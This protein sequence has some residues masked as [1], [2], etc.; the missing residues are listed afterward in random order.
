MCIKLYLILHLIN[1][2]VKKYC[3][4][5]KN[6]VEY[7]STKT[8]YYMRAGDR[9]RLF[10]RYSDIEKDAVKIVGESNKSKEQDVIDNLKQ[11]YK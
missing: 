11:N 9:G 4:Y 3:N 7:K 5:F 6:C 8:I 2:K 10:F 1:L